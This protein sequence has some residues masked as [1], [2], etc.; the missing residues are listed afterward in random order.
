MGELTR[1]GIAVDSALLARFDC[2]ISKQGYTNRSEAF[3]DL[4]RDRLVT[5][6]VQDPEMLVAGT[7]TLIYSHHSRLLP[8]KLTD[9]QHTHHELIIST[10]HVH[11]DH[12]TCLEVIVVRGRSRKVQ[13]LADVLIGT[14]GVQHGRL[15]MSS[16]KLCLSQ[17]A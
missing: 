12:D 6:V 11:L 16:P 13:K 1:T 8:A 9:L 2:F 14:K 4:I 5:D 3:R 10:T 17:T 15:V 7:V